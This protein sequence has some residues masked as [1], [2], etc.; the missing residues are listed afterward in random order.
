MAAT[1][2]LAGKLL[3]AKRENLYWSPCAAHCVELMLEDI[4][5]LPRVK[6][7]IERG[8]TL[9][10]FIYNH[11]STLNMMRKFTNKM[12]LVRYGVTRF[13]TTF[14]TLQRLLKQKCNL[15]KMFTSED[16]L[17]CKISKDARGKRAT[18][19][20]FL[21]TFWKGVVYSLRAMQPL[22]HF[23]RLVDNIKEPAMGYV[24]KAMDRAKDA[25]Q[26]SFNGNEEMYKE[27]FAIIDKRWEC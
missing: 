14:L 27:I 11:S 3:Q 15:G 9:V 23:L 25:I 13:T 16:W 19:T 2:S 4:G 17:K 6:R 26:G 8:I 1:I 22:V 21:P 10:G 24:Y 18:N 20:V 5:K 12:E 7:T